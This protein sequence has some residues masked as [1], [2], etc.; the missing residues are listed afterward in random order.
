MIVYKVR[1]F[2]SWSMWKGR[3]LNKLIFWT[4]APYGCIIFRFEPR[5]HF[6]SSLSMIVR[7][8]NVLILNRTVV[9]SDWLF[10]NLCGSHLQSQSELYLVSW[11]YLT[12]VIDLIGQLS[13]IVVG[14]TC[15]KEEHKVDRGEML[16]SRREATPYKTSFSSFSGLP[17][18]ST[19]FS[20]NW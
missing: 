15:V 11:W 19:V 8:M 18:S 9:D 13:C 7:R 16:D 3:K 20:V 10:D 6:I 12:L 5:N 1:D 14:C 17:R 2:T 4:D